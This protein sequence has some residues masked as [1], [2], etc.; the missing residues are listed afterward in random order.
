MV[1]TYGKIRLTKKSYKNAFKFFFYPGSDWFVEL[2][3][4]IMMDIKG[5]QYFL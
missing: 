4:V 5:V 1:N 2:S 3:F